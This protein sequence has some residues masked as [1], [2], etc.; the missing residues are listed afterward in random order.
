MYHSVLN[1]RIM[2]LTHGEAYELS[3]IPRNTIAF[4]GIALEKHSTR[5]S[6]RIA[7]KR[8]TIG[9]AL[10]KHSTRRSIGIALKR[11]HHRQSIGKA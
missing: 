5:C 10:E 3:T 11:G 7:L 1:L 8:D 2:P 4:I 6:T 9:I